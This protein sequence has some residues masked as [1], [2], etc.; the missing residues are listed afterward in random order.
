LRSGPPKNGDEDRFNII[1]L[2]ME[3]PTFGPLARFDKT[4]DRTR[5]NHKIAA[6]LNP[7]H[8]LKVTSTFGL[9]GLPFPINRQSPDDLGWSGQ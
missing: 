9:C 6:G 3:K 2:L 1:Q 5:F 4:D 7:P 8:P